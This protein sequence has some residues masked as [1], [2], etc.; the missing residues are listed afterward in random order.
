[1]GFN[2]VSVRDGWPREGV[3]DTEI[4]PWVAHQGGVWVHADDKAKKQHRRQMLS[5]GISTLWVKRPKHG[6][7]G[8]DQLRAIAYVIQNYLNRFDAAKGPVHYRVSAHGERTRERIRLE[9]YQL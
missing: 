1:M 3:S 5:S 8:A 6:M 2:A 7:S 9:P 4:I